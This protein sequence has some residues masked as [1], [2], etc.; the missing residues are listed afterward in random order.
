L[1]APSRCRDRFDERPAAP[2]NAAC[3][4]LKA[5]ERDAVARR[6]NEPTV[7]EID[8][9][10]VDL[11]RLRRGPAAPQKSRSPGFSRAN[12]IRFAAG[13]SPLIAKVVRPFSVPAERG[14][15]SVDLSLKT[16][17]TNPEQSKPPGAWTP[18]GAS[19]FS[20]VPPQT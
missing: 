15:A 11:R 20:L 18:N 14:A 9:G 2:A 19:A 13:T 8:P 3:T 6:V 10:V 12:G 16:R 17:Q 1:P 4:S 5:G 7:A